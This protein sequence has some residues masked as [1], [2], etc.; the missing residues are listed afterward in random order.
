MALVS[1]VFDHKSKLL[2]K[3]KVR[4]GDATRDPNQGIIKVIIS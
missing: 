2:D 4:P 1:Q 3:L